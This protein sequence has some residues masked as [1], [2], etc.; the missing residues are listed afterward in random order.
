[1]HEN[2]NQPIAS[3]RDRELRLSADVLGQL[4]D[5]QRRLLEVDLKASAAMRS[6][7]Q[8]LIQVVDALS[9]PL[10]WNNC[11]GSSVQCGISR[12]GKLIDII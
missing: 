2:D 4:D 5:Q 9:R 10:F 7:R 6:Q 12:T 8:E 11:L 3:D 1:M